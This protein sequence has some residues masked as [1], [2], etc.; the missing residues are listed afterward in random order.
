MVLSLKQRI[1]WWSVASTLLIL[2]VVFLFVDRALRN[3]I[4]SDLAES[5]AGGVPFTVALHEAEVDLLLD[6]TMTMALEPTMRAAVETG[7]GATIAENLVP[8]LERF[9][10]EWLAVTTPTGEIMAATESAPIGR[11]QRA[12]R[13]FTEA[14]Y[15][16]TGDLW[17]EREELVQVQAS[18]VLVGGTTT[19]VLVSGVQVGGDLVDRL[20]MATRQRISLRAQ[21]RLLAGADDVPADLRTRFVAAWG[22]S[23]FERA[24][25][26][27]GGQ[28]GPDSLEEIVVGGQQYLGSVIPLPDGSGKPVAY[29][30]VYRSLT[31]ALRPARQMRLALS[32]ITGAGIVLALVLSIGLSRGVTRPV[33]RLMKETVR[34]G[35][36]DLDHPVMP[37]RDDEIGELAQAF[38]QMR[39]SLKQAR[40]ELIRAERLS[41]VGRAASAIIHDFSGPLTII[42]FRIHKLTSDWA[43]EEAREAEIAGIQGEVV[44]LKAMMSEILEFARGVEN[45]DPTEGSVHDLL[46]AVAVGTRPA[47]S[48][49][50]IVLEVL[51]GYDGVWVLD[52]PRTR[53]AL[54]NLI[55][56]A[57]CVLGQQGTV[58]LCSSYGEEGLRL[59]VEDNGPGI[60]EELHET[61][62]EPWVTHG[63]K[64]GTGLGLAIARSF[65]EV[66]GGAIRFETSQVG[67]S[68]ILEFPPSQEV[69]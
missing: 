2:L 58:R 45:V 57:V 67:T 29:L 8:F 62:F 66:Q 63:K 39:V 46:I 48:D 22:P 21:G 13:L 5:V 30:V 43:N 50:D 34:L 10:M 6:R 55:R 49:R 15:Y 14:L 68:F 35:S 47:M 56:N 64:G 53:R 42:N 28:V 20:Q 18:G 25:G 60:P 36:G 59:K 65:T 12:E 3:T 7:D 11:I 1:L 17:M 32:G 52:F 9:N 61:L 37:E 33:D 51:H 19:A 31:E 16:D 40:D 38:D 69:A 41:G 26:E 44:R 4:R 27:G 24:A 23:S 54:E